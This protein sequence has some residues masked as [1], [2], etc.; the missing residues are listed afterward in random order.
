MAPVANQYRI[1]PMVRQHPNRASHA[2]DAGCANEHRM[3][4]APCHAVKPRFEAIELPPVA[5]ATNG[6]INEAQGVLIMTAIDDVTCAENET[7]T[8]SKDG[9]AVLNRADERTMQTR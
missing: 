5:I 1:I 3:K 4:W 2:S 7:S 6:H 8:G 9:Q